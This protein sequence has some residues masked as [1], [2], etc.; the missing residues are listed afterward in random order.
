MEVQCD[1]SKG[2]IVG[3]GKTV[4]DSVKRVAAQDVVFIFYTW[5]TLNYRVLARGTYSRPQ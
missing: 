5:S 3:I 1:G 2:C 4:D